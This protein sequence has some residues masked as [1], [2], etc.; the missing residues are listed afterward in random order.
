MHSTE[1]KRKFTLGKSER[2]CSEKIIS[3][4][5]KPGFF[6]KGHPVQFNY[7]FLEHSDTP[8][9][10][11]FVVSKKRIRTAVNRNRVKRMLRELYRLNKHP[12]HEA[13]ALSGKKV[14]IAVIYNQNSV[15]NYNDLQI[16]YMKVL[17]KLLTA[18]ANSEQLTVNSDAE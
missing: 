5:F 8:V 11:L 12:L 9:K 6:I 2:L 4:L 7:N 15:I 14:A 10:V 1:P 18:L 17:Q 13:L 16:G 3:G